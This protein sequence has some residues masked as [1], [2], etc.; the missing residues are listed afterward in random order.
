M[1]KD[2]ESK[3]RVYA[4]KLFIHKNS[5]IIKCV[6]VAYSYMSNDKYIRKVEKLIIL[7]LISIALTR[8]GKKKKKKYPNTR[9][10]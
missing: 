7:I 1:V 6:Q 3:K 9:A 10:K 8:M 4:R 5:K 2:N